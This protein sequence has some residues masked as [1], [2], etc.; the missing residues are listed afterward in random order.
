MPNT[1]QVGPNEDRMVA[2]LT[3][4]PVVV[5]TYTPIFSPPVVAK[6]KVATK[7]VNKGGKK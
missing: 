1:N 5:T 4:D 2:R 7:E 3:K 6:G